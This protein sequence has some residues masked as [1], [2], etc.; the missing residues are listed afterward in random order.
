VDDF[1]L[2]A[3]RISTALALHAFGKLANMK[4]ATAAANIKMALPVVFTFTG[5]LLT[6]RMRY[7]NISAIRDPEQLVIVAVNETYILTV[8]IVNVLVHRV[9]LLSYPIPAP[10]HFFVRIPAL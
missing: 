3:G 4:N 9:C 2:R 6:V 8:R 10:S 5:D 7:S 1:R